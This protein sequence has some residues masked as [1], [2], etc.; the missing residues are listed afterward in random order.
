MNNGR[1][2]SSPVARR[3]SAASWR[4]GLLDEG[5]R[6]VA[7]ARDVTKINDLVA[8]HAETALALTLGVTDAGAITHAVRRTEATFGQ[9]DV[10]VNNAGYG[11]L[12][13][14]KEGEDAPVRAMFDTNVFGLVNWTKAVLPGGRARRRGHIIN[15]SSIGGLVSFAAAGCFHATK[16]AVE[17]LSGSLAIELAPS[18]IKVTIV[19]PESFR[20]DFAGRSIG[21]SRTEIADYA[22]TAG[23]RR[24]Q[25]F[26]RSSNQQGDPVRAAQAI[27]G[28]V[29][30]PNPPQHLLLGKPALE[31][32]RKDLEAKKHDFDTW[33]KVTLGADCPDTVWE[34][35]RAQWTTPCRRTGCQK[36]RPPSPRSW[37]RVPSR[38]PDRGR[39]HGRRRGCRCLRH[40]V[41]HGGP[42]SRCRP[43]RRRRPQCRSRP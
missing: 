15:L 6:V 10:L 26:A 13:A 3:A 4:R 32:A 41:S 37:P 31:L 40:A 14:I 7:T 30:S 2:G 25:T 12:A 43:L 36:A 1:S 9:I 5:A 39:K 22:E 29:A 11:H 28:A 21:Q 42:R 8:G 27:I 24:K 16:F 23:I 38:G 34:F 35:L 33:E 20:T 17:R 18:N 19:D